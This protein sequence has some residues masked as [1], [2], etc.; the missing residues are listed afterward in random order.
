MVLLIQID[1]GY[2]ADLVMIGNVVDYS[3]VDNEGTYMV[4]YED[5]KQ[6]NELFDVFIKHV[7]GIKEVPNR[8]N[9]KTTTKN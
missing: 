3:S 4:T 8:G 7:I 1:K 5:P 6:N 2:S 9:I